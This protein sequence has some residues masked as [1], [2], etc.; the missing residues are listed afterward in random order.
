MKN[1]TKALFVVGI[2]VAV[3]L[4]TSSAKAY[5]MPS[6]QSY[7]NSYGNSYGQQSYYQ[8]FQGFQYPVYNYGRPQ[9]TVGQLIQ[10]NLNLTSSF[11]FIAPPI[12]Q[13]FYQYYPPNNYGGY[14]Y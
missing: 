13:Y 12:H 9:N 5:Y 7:G 2:V 14:G 4:V 3:G 8:P 11:V 10:S 1:I 6:Y